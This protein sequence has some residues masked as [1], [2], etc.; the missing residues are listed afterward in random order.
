MEDHQSSILGTAVVDVHTV[1][2]IHIPQIEREGADTTAVLSGE[3]GTQASGTGSA[4]VAALGTGTVTGSTPSGV[5][6]STYSA[7]VVGWRSRTA[8]WDDCP[9]FPTRHMDRGRV[10]AEAIVCRAVRV[11]AGLVEMVPLRIGEASS[12]DLANRTDSGKV[13]VVEV[14]MWWKLG[15]CS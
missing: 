6:E 11:V 1:V 15:E 2:E 5:V 9:V 14:K 12:Q 4:V 13:V 7:G 10:V 8:S 3:V